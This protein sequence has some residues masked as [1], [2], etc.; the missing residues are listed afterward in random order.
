MGKESLAWILVWEERQTPPL[1][2]MTKLRLG[3]DVDWTIHLA[4]QLLTPRQLNAGWS[5]LVV[6]CRQKL[7]ANEHE[8][9]QEQS[10]CS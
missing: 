7:Q 1:V 3:D 6:D 2:L 4:D 5:F 8:V 10:Q 9:S